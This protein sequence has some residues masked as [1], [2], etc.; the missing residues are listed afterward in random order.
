MHKVAVD[1]ENGLRN[2]V[3]EDQTASPRQ[4]A[5]RSNGG[6]VVGKVGLKYSIN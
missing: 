1:G 6:G 3:R 4:K 2:D 5:P